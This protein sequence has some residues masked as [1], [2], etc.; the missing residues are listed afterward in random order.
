M[1]DWPAINRYNKQ[2]ILTTCSPKRQTPVFRSRPPH[3]V[4]FPII[5]LSPPCSGGSG[6]FLSATILSC[7]SASLSLTPFPLPCGTASSRITAGT[8]PARFP[9]PSSSSSAV[10]YVPRSDPSSSV[11]L[12]GVSACAIGMGGA[13][14]DGDA[15][16]GPT[17]PVEVEV[18]TEV[19][20]VEELRERRRF[21]AL[22]T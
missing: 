12:N 21:D 14:V 20:A 9:C 8:S 3:R 15:D 13:D 11:M 16:A 2:T 5:P 6:A 10:K 22:M 4:S 7:P 1:Q 19:L 17:E 18:E